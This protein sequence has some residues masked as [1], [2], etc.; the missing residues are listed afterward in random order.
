MDYGA[1]SA[2]MVNS[3]PY[4]TSMENSLPKGCACTSWPMHRGVLYYACDRG[5][6][7]YSRGR[8]EKLFPQDHKDMQVYDFSIK[9]NSIYLATKGMGWLF[10]I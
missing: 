9:D 10:K 6:Y 7:R 2:I 4:S 3:N 1:I 5:F 8:S